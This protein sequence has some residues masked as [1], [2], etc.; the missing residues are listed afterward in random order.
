MLT[1]DTM[2]AEQAAQRLGCSGRTIRRMVTRGELEP[3]LKM[4]GETGAYVFEAAEI[5]RAAA[6]RD[7]EMASG[8]PGP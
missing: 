4:P 7:G 6:R 2:S 5:E 1:G 3:L 8:V